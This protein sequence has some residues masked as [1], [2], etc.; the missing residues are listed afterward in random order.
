MDVFVCWCNDR[1]YG[2][3]DL[4]VAVSPNMVFVSW[5]WSEV[6]MGIVPSQFSW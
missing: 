3:L 4:D 2:V 5:V 6:W 1:L